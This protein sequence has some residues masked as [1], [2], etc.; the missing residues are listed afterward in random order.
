MPRSLPSTA[1]PLGIVLGLVLGLLVSG[2]TAA[3]ASARPTDG[4]ADPQYFGYAVPATQKCAKHVCVHWVTSTADAAST[5]TAKAT[6][7]NWE[8]AWKVLVKKRDYR[9]PLKDHKLGGNGKV[10]IYLKDLGPYQV[11]VTCPR[12]NKKQRFLGQGYCLVDNDFAGEAYGGAS[13]GTWSKVAAARGLFS[14]IQMAYDAEEDGWLVDSTQ[15]WA[16]EQ[17]FDDT[18]LGRNVLGGSQ[19]VRSDIPLD[20][21]AAG[22]SVAWIFFEF[23]AKKHGKD[24][25]R[26]IWQD[27]AADKGSPDY[28][29]IKA[30]TQVLKSRGGF[31]RNFAEFAAVNT[32]PARFYGEGKAWPHA[33]PY[34]VTLGKSTR[35]F[36][37]PGPW[38]LPHLTSASAIIRPDAS[39]KKKSWKLKVKLK[40]PKRKASPGAFLLIDRKKG[41]TERKY[42]TFNRKG[43]AS[44]KVSFSAKK[45]RSVTLSVVNASTRYRCF[46]QNVYSCQG[47]PRDDASSFTWSVKATR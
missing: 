22:T 43:K 4:P 18:N 46:R 28:Y 3:P 21:N 34:P 15:A 42:V 14:L 25:V 1:R 5:A 19:L 31:V 8:K 33:A 40:G 12:E 26:K 35:K 45:V 13:A 6:L 37:T 44:A 11:S 47:T 30:V 20:S 38:V 2:L 36:A 32:Q 17:V 23:L 16:E 39:L 10:D 41:K 7:K 9:A 29:S 24:V 27:V